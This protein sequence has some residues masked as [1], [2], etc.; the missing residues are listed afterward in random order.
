M[1]KTIALVGQ[2]KHSLTLDPS[3]WIFDDRK[4]DLT[5]YFN[6]RHEEEDNHLEEYTKNVS[7]HWDRELT[8]GALFPPINKSVKHFE[9]EKILKG[10]YGMKLKPFIINAEVLDGASKAVLKTEKGETFEITLQ[11]LLDGVVQFSENGKPLQED[12]P[13]YFYF[14]DGSN[15]D[16]PFT[17][18]TEIEVK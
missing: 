14:G 17:N 10:T 3:V 11:Q 9:K 18:I 5:D 12:G 7:A 15:K 6:G 2:L 1:I 8:E 16:T 4:I 13:I